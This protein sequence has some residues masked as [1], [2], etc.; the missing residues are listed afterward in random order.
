MAKSNPKTASETSTHQTTNTD[1]GVQFLLAEFNSIRSFK[2]QS[3]SI[4]DKRVDIFLTLSSA[5]IAGL[6]F[7]SQSGIAPQT[8]LVI[9]F[10]GSFGLL[11]L[12]LVTLYQ[13]IDRDILIIEY[14]HAINGIRGYFAEHAPHIQPYLLMP[15]S[16]RFPEYNW[17][18]SN[19]RIPMVING[20]SFGALCMFSSLFIRNTTTPDFNSITSFIITFVSMYGFQEIYTRRIFIQ[21]QIKADK[22]RKSGTFR[23]HERNRDAHKPNAPTT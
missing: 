23:L 19:R 2:E 22:N 12:G 13:V 20:F 15:T 18:S 10:C 1:I 16:D 7:F 21:A 4:G 3:V 17:Q 6:G 14:I 9:A 11:V 5:L 8:F